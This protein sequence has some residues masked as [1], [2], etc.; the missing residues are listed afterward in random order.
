MS[1]PGFLMIIV[2]FGFLWFVLVRP[3]KRRQVE[4]AANDQR[5]PASAPRSVTA[6]GIY[7]EITNRRR[8]TTKT[9]A[10]R[11]ARSRCGWHARRSAAS[12]PSGK[13]KTKV[14]KKMTHLS[15]LT[16]QNWP[17]RRRAPEARSYPAADL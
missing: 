7:G 12:S 6:G 4:A 15:P 14:R 17:G 3:Q 10:D 11:P 9:G 13:P 1:S 2:A 5:P 8:T 16:S